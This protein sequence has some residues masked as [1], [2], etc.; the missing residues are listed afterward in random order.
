MERK[1]IRA[2]NGWSLFLNST[3]LKL[4][5]VN[6]ETDRVEYVMENNTLKIKKAAPQAEE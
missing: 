2:G 4:L 1:L 3:I 6:P 5:K